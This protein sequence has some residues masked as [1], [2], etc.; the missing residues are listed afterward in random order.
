M[1]PTLA[2][3]RTP[4]ANAETILFAYQLQV[5]ELIILP[6][7]NVSVANIQKLLLKIRRNE[8]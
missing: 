8:T 1:P 7:L 4:A 2:P 5:A 3:P 6:G